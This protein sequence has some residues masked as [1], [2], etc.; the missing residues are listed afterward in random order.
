M[1]RP[2]AYNPIY[3][4]HSKSSAD[5]DA[6]LKL[7]AFRDRVLGLPL[8]RNRL[9]AR[10]A[11][12]CELSLASRKAARFPI[13][14]RMFSGWLLT[15]IW[16]LNGHFL[17]DWTSAGVPGCYTRTET[18]LRDPTTSRWAPLSQRS[19]RR[20]NSLV[21]YYSRGHTYSLHLHPVPLTSMQR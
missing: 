14:L 18:D 2:L 3:N 21:N 7:L 15:N 20:V 12:V 11:V 8:A 17:T 6:D 9:E 5:D 19:V 10:G 13:E 1:T 16:Q 4:S